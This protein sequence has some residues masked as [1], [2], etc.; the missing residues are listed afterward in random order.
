MNAEV[1]WIISKSWMFL[2]ILKPPE[3][4]KMW[5][6]L[7]IWALHYF[8]Y[9]LDLLKMPLLAYLLSWL[10]QNTRPLLF[11]SARTSY[12]TFDSRPSARKKKPDH[13]NSLIIYHG[14]TDNLSNHIFSESWWHPLSSNPRLTHPSPTQTHHTHKT[15]PQ[16]TLFDHFSTLCCSTLYKPYIFWKL[17]TPT[18]Q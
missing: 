7:S 11:R 14:T 16:P 10:T 6:L 13:L 9:L 15:H 17:V 1:D 5:N 12:S 4:N 8:L 3:K 2:L 18:I